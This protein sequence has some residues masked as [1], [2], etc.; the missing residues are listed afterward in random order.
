[1]I[2]GA[3]ENKLENRWENSEGDKKTLRDLMID[4]V[5]HLKEHTKHFEQT[6]QEINR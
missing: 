6:L 1:M 2:R 3:D 4:Y 5:R